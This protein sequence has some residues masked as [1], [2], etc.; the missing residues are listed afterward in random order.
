MK[1]VVHVVQVHL[2]LESHNVVLC[3]KEGHNTRVIIVDVILL[4]LNDDDDDDEQ[5]SW[6]CSSEVSN[7]DEHTSQVRLLL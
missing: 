1:I 2:G 5:H 3:N 6:S 4:G 7:V